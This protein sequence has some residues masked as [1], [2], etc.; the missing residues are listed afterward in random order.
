MRCEPVAHRSQSSTS[1]CGWKANL[2]IYIYIY[3]EEVERYI[4]IF[5]SL[6][7]FFIRN[8][9]SEAESKLSIVY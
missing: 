6:F 5:A 7:F 1:F 3:I 4:F 2:I 8:S 9:L